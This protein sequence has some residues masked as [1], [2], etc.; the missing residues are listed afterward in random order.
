MK[1]VA[2]SFPW[3]RD[4]RFVYTQDNHNSAVGM[5]ELALNAGASAVAV[6]FVPDIPEGMLEPEE[7]QL[8]NPKT[9]SLLAQS[10]LG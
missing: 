8:C 1:L 6:N 3:S 7:W 9:T 4:S 5:R 10:L 2:E